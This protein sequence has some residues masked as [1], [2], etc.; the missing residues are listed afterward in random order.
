MSNTQKVY[1]LR[2][3]VPE[4]FGVGEESNSFES[5]YKELV[6]LNNLVKMNTDYSDMQG[7]LAENKDNYVRLMKNID[8]STDDV[9]KLI[10]KFNERKLL[11]REEFEKIMAV[12]IN[13]LGTKKDEVKEK[14]D[15]IN[16]LE[17][18]MYKIQD[19]NMYILK[20]VLTYFCD[21]AIFLTEGVFNEIAKEMQNLLDEHKGKVNNLLKVAKSRFKELDVIDDEIYETK[22]IK[23]YISSIEDKKF[24]D[25][26][27][28]ILEKRKKKIEI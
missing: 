16:K 20:E 5:K 25:K 23:G 21:D 17:E 9:K 26:Y 18:K 4:I 27:S 12:F 13:S 1:S 15:I 10:K 2:E 24:K 22:L 28:R 7:V 6:R 8:T 3:L 19:E 11:T 14:I